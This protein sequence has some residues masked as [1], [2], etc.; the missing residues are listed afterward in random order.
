MKKNEERNSLPTF[1]RRTPKSKDEIYQIWMKRYGVSCPY[2]QQLLVK[3]Q[4]QECI[5]K[6]HKGGDI[7]DLKRISEKDKANY[8]HEQ[9]MKI[10]GNKGSQILSR[11]NEY[12]TNTGV[13]YFTSGELRSNKNNFNEWDV[14][15]GPILFNSFLSSNKLDP[16]PVSTVFYH[17]HASVE[18]DQSESTGI[19]NQIQRINH[20]NSNDKTVDL[21]ESQHKY[22]SQI[23]M[24]V[25]KEHSLSSATSH[26]P[27]AETINANRRYRQK[28][29][30]KDFVAVQQSDIK[31]VTKHRNKD[32]FHQH[33]P[34]FIPKAIT[35][36]TCSL[37][38]SQLEWEKSLLAAR[39]LRLRGVKQS[40]PKILQNRSVNHPSAFCDGALWKKEQEQNV[41]SY[42]LYTSVPSHV[43]A[44]RSQVLFWSFTRLTTDI[45]V[46]YPTIKASVVP[47]VAL[48]TSNSCSISSSQ[49]A[50]ASS[51]KVMRSESNKRYYP[52]HT[53]SDS[54]LDM[55]RKLFV[56]ILCSLRLI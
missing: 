6:L 8:I 23:K 43:N 10:A 22:L 52:E 31:I 38:Q 30:L 42:S 28:K 4:K 53:S 25:G 44:K 50:A 20:V 11:E 39:E 41:S 27:T 54:V 36:D 40:T 13:D 15:I 35:P 33:F 47:E 1:D 2:S 46:N 24:G 29:K 32:V 18:T 3:E 12:V 5:P 37:L 56:F 17:P 9:L 26:V 21:N 7:G 34:S 16:V 14:N 49:Y 19:R 48:S 45:Y 51:E 55:V